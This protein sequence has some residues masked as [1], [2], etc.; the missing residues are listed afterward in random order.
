M[1]RRA[2]AHCL[3]LQGHGI[4]TCRRHEPPAPAQQ[5]GAMPEPLPYAFDAVDAVTAA[6]AAKEPPTMAAA[7]ADALLLAGGVCS[8]HN[9]SHRV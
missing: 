9:G 3:L 8:G 5:R 6:A 2:Q 1:G 4:A 7:S